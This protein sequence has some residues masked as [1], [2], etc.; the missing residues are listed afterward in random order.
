MLRTPT[1]FLVSVALALG[2]CSP[3]ADDPPTTTTT[4]SQ[5]STSTTLADDAEPCS[6]GDLPFVSDGLVGAIGAADGDATTITQ[7]RWEPGIE[8]ERIVV[9]FATESGAPATSLGPSGVT[10]FGFA[11]LIRVTLPEGVVATSVA[12]MLTDGA[13]LETTYVV[14]D[15]SDALTIDLHGSDGVPLA[16][17]AFVTGSPASLVIDLVRDPNMA[18]PS[19][20]AV[21]GTAVVVTPS[22]GPGLYPFIVSAYVQP[23]LRTV[24]LQ[25]SSGDVIALDRTISLDGFT[26]AWQ[27]FETRVDDGPGGQSVLFVGQVDPNGRPID[28]ASIS[29]DLP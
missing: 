24:T 22:S 23:G 12:D 10:N 27:S 26:D 18:A 5:S 21:A 15:E 9:S 17:R 16:A 13:L 4:I 25:L 14:R 1:F 28:G 11:G 3:E 7:I 6:S 29:L 2:A 20:A 8:C 19:G